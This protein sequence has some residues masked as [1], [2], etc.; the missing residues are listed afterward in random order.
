MT[1][2]INGNNAT[3]E[4]VNANQVCRVSNN[5]KSWEELRT[6]KNFRVAVLK[7]T[8][9]IE[10]EILTRLKSFNIPFVEK[11]G[12]LQEEQATFNSALCLEIN[13]NA[14]IPP[15]MRNEVKEVINKVLEDNNINDCYVSVTGKVVMWSINNIDKMVEIN[16]LF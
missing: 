3:N 14:K 8:A 12:F 7:F 15:P 5:N 16:T 1:N 13:P 6:D 2:L 9:P 10:K 11:I 4:S